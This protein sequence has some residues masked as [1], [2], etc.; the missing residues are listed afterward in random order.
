MTDR[1]IL[2]LEDEINNIQ[3]KADEARRFM[4][5]D[6]YFGSFETAER[7]SSRVDEEIARLNGIM[8][9]LTVMGYRL[10]WKDDRRVIVMA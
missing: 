5:A 4:E 7:W 2:M 1:Q 3:Q 6:N 8:I 9:A 10:A